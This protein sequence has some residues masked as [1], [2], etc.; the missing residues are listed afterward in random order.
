MSYSSYILGRMQKYDTPVSIAFFS[1]KNIKIIQHIIKNEVTRRSEGKYRLES[2]QDIKDLLDI[3][4]SIYFDHSKNNAHNIEN[5]VNELNRILIRQI[6]PE[7]M[8]N[9]KQFYDFQRDINGPLRTI[10]RPINV[11]NA[12]RRTLPSFTTLWS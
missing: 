8:S 2:D 4:Q 9:I 3:M 7:I 12:G 11:N 6:M 5:E 1:K 10:P